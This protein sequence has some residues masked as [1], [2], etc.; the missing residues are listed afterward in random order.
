MCPTNAAQTRLCLLPV[1]QHS[2][3]RES[4]ASLSEN[5]SRHLGEN[6]LSFSSVSTP[7]TFRREKGTMREWGVE[8]ARAQS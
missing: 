1:A 4:S 6:I 8:E 7:S 5:L 2:V 3:G